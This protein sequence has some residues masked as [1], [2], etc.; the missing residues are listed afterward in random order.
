[1]RKHSVSCLPVVQNGK[2]VG[3]ITERDFLK[4]TRDLLEERLATS[5]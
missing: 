5:T 2:L 3:M 4:I 1:M